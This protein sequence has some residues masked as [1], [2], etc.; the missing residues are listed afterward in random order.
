MKPMVQAG[1]PAGSTTPPDGA[2]LEGSSGPSR[3]PAELWGHVRDAVMVSD[4]QYRITVWNRGAER[5]Y[6]WRESEVL[7]RSGLE[8]LA[9]EFAA[10]EKTDVLEQL[11]R[12]G[13]YRG[14]A[15]QLRKDGGRIQVE[16]DSIVLRG[17]DDHITG[18]FSINRDISHRKQ[19]EARILESEQFLRAITQGLPGQIAY[20]DSELRCVFANQAHVEWWGRTPEQMRGLHMRDLLGPE[21]WRRNLPAIEGALAGIP[22]SFER[23]HTKASG[24]SASIWVQYVPDG[25]PG[26]C[27]GMFVVVNDITERKRIEA[28]LLKTLA[29]YKTLTDSAPYAIAS[30]DL[31]GT[32]TSWN[33]AATR[34]LGYT[35]AEMVGQRMPGMVAGDGSHVAHPA[36]LSGA[37]R[38][39]A[40]PAFPVFIAGAG[41]GSRAGVSGEPPAHELTFVRKDGT[42]LP[43]LMGMAAIRDAR[44]DISG[45]LAMAADITGRKQM[46]TELREAKETAEHASQAKSDFLATM[47]HEIRTPLNGVIGL[48]NL[49][50]H[51]RLDE[52]QR[53]LALALKR[54]GD[55]L[56]DLI[57]D[58]L[59]H[60]KLEAGK[61]DIE[62][63]VFLVDT[64]I[65][66]ILEVSRP[67]A[68]EKGLTLGYHR[69]AVED[70]AASGTSRAAAE[71]GIGPR[72]VAADPRRVRQVLLNL[73]GN[74]I[75][76][77]DR[78]AIVLSVTAVDGPDA[79]TG[80]LRIAVRD[81]GMGIPDDQKDR[82]FKRFSQAAP[83]TTRKFGGTGLGLAISALLVELMGGSIGFESRASEG[84]T[85]W[86]DLPRAELTPAATASIAT[87]LGLP[88]A[89][90]ESSAVVTSARLEGLRVL[91]AED[92]LVN[93][94]VAAGLLGR[95]GCRVDIASN[96]RHAVELARRHPYVAI[97]MDC[98]MPELDGFAAAR[99]I[100]RA[101]KQSGAGASPSPT[102]GA[103][104]DL[105]LARE[106]DG[107][108]EGEGA[109][110]PAAA[111]PVF[112]VA[113]TAATMTEERERC[114]ASGMDAFLAKPFDPDDLR[115][116]L[117]RALAERRSDD[118][119]CPPAASNSSG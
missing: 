33:P 105:A 117:L 102:P 39:E 42:Q 5:L 71:R 82:I 48:S 36:Q 73:V 92:N 29:T 72:V 20:W 83:S 32:I 49:L 84:S 100:R 104:T 113:L 6:G 22:Q 116:L 93:Q 66:E 9:T 109:P 74:A 106:G 97:F 90:A 76:F 24:Q 103:P 13:Y 98:Q 8:L 91:V 80:R 34:M 44:G 12:S 35:E 3:L 53:E 54:S 27:K 52:G 57:R 17:S 88:S 61:V 68:E 31:A 101:E 65:D 58:V 46:E 2:S 95:L 99:E 108:G 78:G 1:A 69:P 63:A 119:P 118:R 43:V 86:I 16:V 112:I 41:T 51:T 37:E 10:T 81:S 115:Q 38:A 40:R 14:D 60:A 28:D 55:I 11:Q 67:L 110:G 107:E 64:V 62:T 87:A 114:L 18:Y 96:G 94:K 15:T 26:A 47:S 56:L 59:D 21:L 30:T 89:R 19:A 111:R 23:Q 25:A 45:Y 75:K 70:G 85:F 79:G 77:T 50:M 7:G 4:A